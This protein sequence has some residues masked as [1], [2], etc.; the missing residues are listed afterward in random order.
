MSLQTLL[1][2]LYLVTMSSKN[3]SGNDGQAMAVSF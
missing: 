2:E 1:S 3:F